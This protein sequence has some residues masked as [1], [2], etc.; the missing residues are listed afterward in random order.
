MANVLITTATANEKTAWTKARLDV[1]A[2]LTE[3]GYQTVALPEMT[4]N[5]LTWVRFASEIRAKAA[6]GGHALMEY[7]IGDRL[8]C[9]F[10]SLIGRLQNVKT[11]A[12]IHDL[13]SLRS[14]DSPISR[15]VGFLRSFDGVISHN[16]AMTRWLQQA[17]MDKRIV[18]LELF[19]YCS[20]STEVWHAPEPSLPWQVV[21]AGNLSPEKAGYVY[22]P[23]LG[24]LEGV[25]ISLYGAFFRPEK[26][27]DSPVRYKGVFE[28]DFPVLDR[29]YHFGLIWDGDDV[30]RCGGIFGHYM[31]FNNPHKL[32][33]YV[34][35][36]L[37]VIVWK[38]AAIARFVTENQIGVAVA[39]LRDMSK[40]RLSSDEYQT[41]IAN[42]STL[43]VRVKGGE[44]LN[45]ALTRL[46]GHG[47]STPRILYEDERHTSLL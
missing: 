11:Y 20:R 42:V 15:E 35:M 32:S 12:L 9:Y 10:V 40:I 3:R 19:D 4:F 18:N 22:N 21:C 41:M 8:R 29:K 23:R 5:P 28:P 43:S 27:P 7:P 2:L 44:F 14:A 36:G 38:E 24:E 17:G 25:E 37:P 26:M 1:K 31:R 45:N 39:D 13:N 33:L 30:D 47:Q 46:A 6:D 34:A 16:A